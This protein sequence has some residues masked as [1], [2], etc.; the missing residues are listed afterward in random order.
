MKKLYTFF[1]ALFFFTGLSAQAPSWMYEYTFG[2]GHNELFRHSYEHPD[3]GYITIS[4]YDT[5]S[6]NCG[7]PTLVKTDYYGNHEWLNMP[8]A[9]DSSVFASNVSMAPLTNGYII[10]AEKVDS[11]STYQYYMNLVY[12]KDIFLI[13]TDLYGDTMWTKELFITPVSAREYAHSIRVASDGGYIMAGVLVD[14]LVLNGHLLV[15]KTDSAGNIDWTYRTPAQWPLMSYNVEEAPNGDFVFL[16]GQGPDRLLR[17]SSTGSL[18]YDNVNI[19]GPM[20]MLSVTNAY[21]GGFMTSGESSNGLGIMRLNDLGDTIW[22][23]QH[24]FA[25]HP[26]TSGTSI[27][28]TLDSNYVIAGFTYNSSMDT[29]VAYACKMDTSGTILWENAYTLPGASNMRGVDVIPTSDYGYLITGANFTGTWNGVLIKIDSTGYCAIPPLSIGH[30]A[31]QSSTL[32]VYP[33]PAADQFTV[34]LSNWNGEMLYV[35]LFDM[36]G[37]KQMSDRLS[38]AQTNISTASLSNGLYLV[39][40]KNSEGRV[41]H[42][43]K[44][45]V[46]R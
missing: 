43:S 31:A 28:R 13:R 30:P 26:V 23:M 17:L 6:C 46:K 34:T 20:G 10:A 39:Q 11:N 7:T 42:D 18:V 44:L 35:E 19:S 27:S 25:G 9:N 16:C 5:S 21:N 14:T 2:A 3:G 36:T 33:N 41:L 24:P 37:R 1:T 22:T 38:T 29:I 4:S 32:E 40:V 15:V 45:V 8:L 12:Q